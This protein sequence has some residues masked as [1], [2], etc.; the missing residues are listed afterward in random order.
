MSTQFAAAAVLTAFNKLTGN[1]ATA[2]YTASEGST[3]IRSIIA[4]E[5]NGATPTLTLEVYDVANTTSYYLR[6]ALAL[7]AGTPYV[8]NEPFMLPA[9]WSIRATSSDA[10]GRIDVHVAYEDPSASGSPR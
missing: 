2:I 3:L 9:N 6:K 7:S 4:C 10:S 1:T 5:T 8:F